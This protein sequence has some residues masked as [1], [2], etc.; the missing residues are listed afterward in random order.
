M[1]V[2]EAESRLDAARLMPVQSKGWKKIRLRGD[3]QRAW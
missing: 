3:M 2:I 1:Q